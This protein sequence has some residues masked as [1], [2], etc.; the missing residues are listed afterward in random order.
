MPL[1][2]F[3]SRRIEDLIG[4][5]KVIG[6]FSKY[7]LAFVGA[8]AGPEN[9]DKEIEAGELPLA[10]YN[11]SVFRLQRELGKTSSVRFSF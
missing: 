2:L 9:P 5:G 7:N 1:D 10:D 3:Y 4:G 6:K 11:Y 8:V